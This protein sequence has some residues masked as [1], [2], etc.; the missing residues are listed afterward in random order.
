MKS[1]IILLTTLL[2][3]SP[4][5]GLSQKT[6]EDRLAVFERVWSRVNE[7]YFDPSFGGLDWKEVRSRYR[8]RIAAAKNDEE[9]HSLINA[10][11]WELKVSHAAFVPPGFF[12]NVEPIVFAK[13]GIGINVRLLDGRVVI[14]SVDAGS[15]AEK[16]GLRSG[17]IVQAI[18]SYTTKQL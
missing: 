16:A 13:G 5:F 15:P 6:N 11:L 9:F 4:A 12:A 8:P 7:T 14:S 3:M 18:E 17:F 2:S 1:A 10:M